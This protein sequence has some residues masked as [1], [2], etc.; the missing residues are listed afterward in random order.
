MKNDLLKIARTLD[1]IFSEAD[2]L[3][4]M[5]QKETFEERD[6]NTV[7]GLLDI[8]INLGKIVK[9]DLGYGEYAYILKENYERLSKPD[10]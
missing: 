2:I 8:Y 4:V 10:R 1:I 5:F 7:T 6:A 9:I 3:G